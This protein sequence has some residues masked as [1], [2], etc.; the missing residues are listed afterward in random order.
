[1][2]NFVEQLGV[3]KERCKQ[4]AEMA[5]QTFKNGEDIIFGMKP[6]DNVDDVFDSIGKHQQ[7]DVKLLT[8]VEE[9]IIY[10]CITGELITE[11]RDQIETVIAIL[12]AAG[13]DAQDRSL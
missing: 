12:S 9:G 5:V 10:G 1:M 4:I 6:G 3:S 11:Y 13:L 8:S 7:E 2:K